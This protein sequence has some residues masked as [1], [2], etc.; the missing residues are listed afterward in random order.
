MQIK[1]YIF[2]LTSFIFIGTGS[3]AQELF[4]KKELYHFWILAGEKLDA[5]QFDDALRLYNTHSE[6]PAFSMKVR[7]ISRIKRNFI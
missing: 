2:C 6:N 1:R 3:S 5:G 4:P 7:Q